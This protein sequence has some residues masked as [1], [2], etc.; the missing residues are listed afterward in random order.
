MTAPS[1]PTSEFVGRDEEPSVLRARLDQACAGAGAVAL[2]FGEPGVG[3]TLQLR[4]ALRGD[5]EST[6]RMFGVTDGTVPVGDFFAPE[7]LQRV[8]AVARRRQERL[9][10]A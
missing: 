3:R 7:N 1:Y 2:L 6:D 5:Q 4:A 10:T 9:V 8:M